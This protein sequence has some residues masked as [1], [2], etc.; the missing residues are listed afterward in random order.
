MGGKRL[1][2]PQHYLFGIKAYKGVDIWNAESW[3]KRPKNP[4]MESE[5]DDFAIAI[6]LSDFRPRETSRDE[7]DY[8]RLGSFID[9][10][11]PEN[12]WIEVGF[13]ARGVR[14]MS[15]ADMNFKTTVQRWLRDEH[16]PPWGPFVRQPDIR[17]LTHYASVQPPRLVLTAEPHREFFFDPDGYGTFISC[18][19]VVRPPPQNDLSTHCQH[20]FFLPGIKARVEVDGVRD[21]ADLARWKEIEANIRRI[22]HSFIVS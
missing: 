10:P 8:R 16:N 5:L 19:T 2:I 6:R 3:A 18:E 13:V 1:A 21:K 7:A 12:R 22:V 9:V 15:L 4:T 20:S 14:D 11:P 17:G